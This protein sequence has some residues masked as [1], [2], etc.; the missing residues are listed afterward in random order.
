MERNAAVLLCPNHG[1]PVCEYC[2]RCNI[3]RCPSCPVCSHRMKTSL[4]EYCSGVQIDLSVVSALRKM[5][6]DNGNIAE[7]ET[8]K[9][10]KRLMLQETIDYYN[11]I[12]LIRETNAK[13]FRKVFSTIKNELGKHGDIVNRF[14]HKILMIFDPETT[15][16]LS[17]TDIKRT[18]KTNKEALSIVTNK[19][20]RKQLKAQALELM[21][22]TDPV[23]HKNE[24]YYKIAYKLITTHK[25]EGHM[26]PVIKEYELYNNA[27]YTEIV[28]AI[29]HSPVFDLGNMIQISKMETFDEMPVYDRLFR[30]FTFSSSGFMAF[31][32]G[33]KI[34]LAKQGMSSSVIISSSHQYIPLFFGDFL[35]LFPVNKEPIRMAHVHLLMLRPEL[36]TFETYDNVKVEGF[37]VV[38]G[39]HNKERFYFI[40]K[41]N[42]RNQLNYFNACTKTIETTDQYIDSF[43]ETTGIALSNY[44][45]IYHNDLQILCAITDDDQYTEVTRDPAF[46][47][48]KSIIPSQSNPD[49]IKQAIL[50]EWT[51]GDFIYYYKGKKYSIKQQLKKY[52]SELFRLARNVFCMSD[53]TSHSWILLKVIVP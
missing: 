7:T 8:L 12:D 16:Y 42:L 30:S 9:E 6:I 37:T 14:L 39:M 51:V 18:M 49:D 26:S 52:F 41:G 36:S 21:K 44:D 13:V 50:V 22:T 47:T 20:L 29:Y 19:L 45:C 4:E 53:P 25:T 40:V 38:Q 48:I 34:A 2:N 5:E 1:R 35:I 23:L 24:K 17:D 32:F 33:Y 43:V 28:Q 31:T 46:Y 15:I 10:E 3:F 11:N 27:F